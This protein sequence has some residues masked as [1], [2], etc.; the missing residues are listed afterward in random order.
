MTTEQ[1]TTSDPASWRVPVQCP[2]PV[3]EPAGGRSLLPVLPTERPR[4]T[5]AG[6]LVQAYSDGNASLNEAQRDIKPRCDRMVQAFWA[7]EQ[8]LEELRRF[9]ERRAAARATAGVERV[10]R[11]HAQDGPEDRRQQP[12]WVTP[13]LIWPVFVASAVYDTVFIGD[14]MQQMLDAAP[15]TFEYFVS[16]L[17]GLGIMVGLLVTAHLL[18]VA[19]TRRRDRLERRPVRTFFFRFKRERKADD[20]GWPMWAFP[21][22]FGTFVLGTL[23]A[24]AQ[25]RAWISSADSDKQDVTQYHSYSVALL[26][27]LSVSA[28]ALRM[29][30]YNPFAVSSKAADAR[31]A[32]ALGSAQRLR[33]GATQRISAHAQAWAGVQAALAGA[34]SE[35]ERFVDAGRARIMEL[36]AQRAA[37]GEQIAD[38]MTPMTLGLWDVDRKDSADRPRTIDLAGHLRL[39]LEMLDWAEGLTHRYTPERLEGLL[40]Q[41]DD[42][43]RPQFGV[44]DDAE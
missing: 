43:L 38:L 32:E 11:R 15:W 24:W 1:I 27:L 4:E 18:A 7:A 21:L 39:R 20:L 10:S 34:K 26:L 13:W 16:Y 31:M 23:G 9:T 41:N 2:N 5:E 6:I 14:S 8:E 28:I 40:S 35:A 3:P 25:I 44:D 12:K 37:G 33:D 29:L 36:R 42:L 17:P 19:H 22:I 30:A